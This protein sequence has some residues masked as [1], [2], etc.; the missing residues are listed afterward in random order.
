[1]MNEE[2]ETK[3]YALGINAFAPEEGTVHP[4]GDTL[5]QED[6]GYFGKP[7]F[8]DYSGF[9]LPENYGYDEGL[10]GEFNELAAKYNLSQKGADELMSM[11]VRLSQLTG[12]NYSK[13]L[14]EKQRQQAESYRS[15]LITDREIGGAKLTKSIA[16]A[17]IA[18]SHFVDPETQILLQQAGLNCHPCIVKMFC[19]I[20]RQMQNDSVLGANISAPQKETREEILFP[21][22]FN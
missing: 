22:M 14:A 5:P 19:Q 10:L 13:T 9:E 4:N 21:T 8:Y 18:Y 17:N 7:E 16:T 11:A 3:N 12:D 2:Q 1:M 15:A 6:G 20:G